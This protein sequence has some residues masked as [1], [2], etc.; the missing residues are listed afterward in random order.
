MKS[1]KFTRE[2]DF[3]FKNTI[4]IFLLLTVISCNGQLKPENSPQ[5]TTDIVSPILPGANRTEMYLPWLAGK[6]VGVVTNQTGVIFKPYQ[7][8][9]IRTV[10]DKQTGQMLEVYETTWKYDRYTHLVDSLL[11]LGVQITKVFAPEH[12]FR[13]TADAG[14]IVKDGKDLKTG[15]PIIS[16]YGKNKKP[17]PKQLQDIDVLIFDIQDVG[18]RFYTY[19]STLHYVLEAAAENQIPVIILDRPNPNIHYIDGPILETAYRSFVGMH[20]VPIVHGLTIAEFA[21]MINGEKWLENQVVCQLLLV[22]VQNYSRTSSYSLPIAPSPNLPND[23]A[24]NLYPSTCLFEGTTLSEGRGTDMQFQI[25][26][27]PFLPQ[28]KYTLKFTPQPNLGSKDPKYNGQLCYGKDLR[29]TPTL[30]QINLSWIMEAYQHTTEKE[31]FFT[32][33]FNTL[34]GNST[35]QQQIKSGLTEEEIRA[36]WQDGLNKYD[37]IRKKYFI[38]PL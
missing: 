11:T 25:F 22:P 36:S 31:S 14:E 12:G 26:G 29:N 19:I 33:F 24:I 23:K 8:P 16:L 32:N 2:I 15:L 10:M 20:P 1:S 13:G 9:A 27:A 28:E 30:N 5:T 17:S 37:S 38:Y 21:Q 7:S 18:A 4:I 35:L 3:F 6:K 34:T